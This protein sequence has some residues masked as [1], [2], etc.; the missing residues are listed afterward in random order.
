[1]NYCPKCRIVIRGEKSCCPLCQGKVTGVPKDFIVPESAKYE[2]FPVIERKISS[3][4]FIKIVTFVFLALE[5]C[6]GLVNWML[7][8]DAPWVELVMLGIF[9]GW[10]DVLG[11]MYVR[12]NIIKLLTV[13][14]YVSIAVNCYVDHMTGLHGWSYAWVMP[15]VLLGLGLLTMLI[16]TVSGMRRS[17]YVQYFVINAAVSLLQLIPI[18]REIN[19]VPLPALIVI[20]FYLILLAG[21]LVFRYRDL[22]TSLARRFNV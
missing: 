16:S 14:A 1:M 9:V 12:G 5:I 8:G 4:T 2:A 15:F 21:V 6:F 13:E 18:S 11:M 3:V 17:E 22:K 10:L 7:R 19:P 20:A